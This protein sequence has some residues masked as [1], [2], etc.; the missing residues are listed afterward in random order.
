MGGC[1]IDYKNFALF[2]DDSIDKQIEI[3]YDNVLIKN[4]DIFENEMEIEESLCSDS[5]LVFGSCEAS[6][7]KFQIAN[8]FSPMFGKEITVKIYLGKDAENKLQIGKYR[9]ASDTPTADKKWREI[10]AYDAIYTITASD[11]AEWYNTILPNKDS[12]VT[13]REFRASFAEHFGLEEEEID[14]INDDMTIERTVEPQKMSGKNVFT[15]ICEINA[16]FGHITREGKLRYVYLPQLIQGLY[17]RNDLYPKND[18]YPRDPQTTAIGAAGTYISCTYED[19][20]VQEINK[21][22]IRQ[23]ENDIGT[24]YPKTEP[25]EDDNC[26]IIQNNFLVYGKSAAE[27]DKIA[28]RIY[29]R[30]TGIIYRPFSAEVKGNPCFE[31]G[32]PVA[33]VTRYERIETYIFARSLR[34]IQA[35]RDEFSSTG[36]E[37]RGENI[38]GINESI[39]QL[40]GKTNTL[41]RTVDE[42]KSEITDLGA[43]LTSTIQQTAQQLRIEMNNEVDK[44]NSKIT[45]TAKDLQIEFNNQAEGLNSKIQANAGQISAEITRATESEGKLSTRIIATANSITA[46]INRATAAEGNLSSK[47]SMTDEKIAT[48]VTRAKGEEERLSTRITQTASDIT[49]EVNRATAAEGNLSSKIALNADSIT[50]EVK[51]ASDAEGTLS[52]RI[53]VTADGLSSEVSRAKGSESALSS[54][55]SQKPNSISLSVSNGSTTAGISIVLKDESGKQVGASASGTIQMTG[56]VKFTDLSGTG[57]TTINGANIKTGTISADR[58]DSDKLKVRAANITGTLV[59]GQLPTKDITTITENAIKTT[60]VTAEYLHVKSANI[61]GQITA[62]ALNVADLYAL[63]AKIGGFTIGQSS[64]YK[65]TSSLTSTYAGVYLGTDGFR[66]YYN[67]NS[68]TTITGGKLTTNN[69]EI[70]GK[71]TASSGYIGNGSHGFTI[72]NTSIYNGKSSLSS[73]GSGVYIGTDGISCG[74]VTFSS[75]GNAGISGNITATGGSIGGFTIAKSSIYSGKSS[76]SSTTN[77]VYIGTDGISLGPSRTYFNGI[78]GGNVQ[79]TTRPAFMVGSSGSVY[80]G[81]DNLSVG[82]TVGIWSGNIAISN[83]LLI[84]SSS[85]RVGSVSSGI[86]ISSSGIECNSFSIG[87]AGST[88]LNIGASSGYITVGKSGA[89]LGFFGSSGSTIKTVSSVSNTSNV[90]MVGSALNALISALKSYGLIA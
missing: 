89:K 74:G 17:P 48:E 21:L 1:L 50:A 27:L 45:L 22:Q 46:E 24:I 36:S 47:I 63:N 76:L 52:T 30:I 75:S 31:V 78:W 54:R 35:L 26:Y 39:I 58:I 65:G 4:V 84:T 85:I 55:I 83:S 42:T 7:I 81:A 57:T 66:N 70:T 73:T 28:E 9:V 56:L 33:L 40:L 5:E 69:A 90:S 51:R 3:T 8:I 20:L 80:L 19:Y 32:D 12:T 64:I 60:N 53:Q 67:S 11:V 29:S 38:N 44:L 49:L 25:S 37:K 68:Y 43:G 71:V 2:E 82:G 18:L 62:D 14:L 87:R 34:G 88:F 77:G 13:M 79:T 59:I 6:S 41:I 15:A 16:C 72:T 10:I 23:E 86:T 61:Q